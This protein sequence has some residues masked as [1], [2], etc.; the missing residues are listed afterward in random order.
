MLLPVLDQLLHLLPPADL[1]GVPNE[2]RL[3]QYGH[4]LRR[5]GRRLPRLHQ[6]VLPALTLDPPSQLGVGIVRVRDE[7]VAV[8]GTELDQLRELLVPLL[9]VEGFEPTL[10]RG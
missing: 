1:V 9:L 3:L 2:S 5:H 10:G 6:L 4:P 8:G 7:G